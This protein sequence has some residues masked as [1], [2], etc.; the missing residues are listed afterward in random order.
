MTQKSP[1]QRWP[2]R[3]PP[4]GERKH[5]AHDRMRQSTG[6]ME[7]SPAL[8][9][10]KRQ[11]VHDDGA[12]EEQL[13]LEV[14]IPEGQSLEEMSLRAV[15]YWQDLDQSMQD[16]WKWGTAPT[17]TWLA[18]GGVLRQMMRKLVE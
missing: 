4:L 13:K 18:L 11:Q 9:S 8:V 16:V 14:Q 17:G 15:G 5:T 2:S 3:A 1:Q 7:G 10:G 12:A 6:V